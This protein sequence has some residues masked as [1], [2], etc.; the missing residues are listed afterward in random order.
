MAASGLKPKAV[1]KRRKGFA[2]QAVASARA[3]PFRIG[4]DLRQQ[5]AR[6]PV[7]EGARI[8]LLDMRAAH[9]RRDACNAPQTDRWSCR[10][11]RR[12]SDRHA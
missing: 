4:Q 3:Q 7:A 12:G 9:D 8:G 2:S 5:P 1:S 11:D 6:Q 10:R